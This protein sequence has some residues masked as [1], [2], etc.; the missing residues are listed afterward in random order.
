MAELL[1]ALFAVAGIALAT[2][3]IA[4]WRAFSQAAAKKVPKRR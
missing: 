1:A 4:A 3:T 2:A